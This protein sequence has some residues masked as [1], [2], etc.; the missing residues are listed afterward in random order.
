MVLTLQILSASYLTITYVRVQRVKFTISKYMYLD[1]ICML[2]KY[3][4]GKVVLNL[5]YMYESET[6]ISQSVI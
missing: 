2:L 5:I 6:I 3:Y 4:K 1:K